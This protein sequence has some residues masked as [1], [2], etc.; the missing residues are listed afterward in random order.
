MLHIQSAV[1]NERIADLRRAADRDRRVRA[2][3]MAH[4]ASVLVRVRRRVRRPGRSPR[5]ATAASLSR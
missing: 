3:R 5:A 4:R 1:A 2:A